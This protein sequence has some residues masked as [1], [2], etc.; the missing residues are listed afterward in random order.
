[1]NIKYCILC[2]IILILLFTIYYYTPSETFQNNMNNELIKMGDFYL[3]MD[4][5]YLAFTS[6][7]NKSEV[8]LS[9]RK[10]DSTKKNKNPVYYNFD[11]KNISLKVD[12]NLDEPQKWKFEKGYGNSLLIKTSNEPSFY[13]A[14]NCDGKV[15]TSQLKRSSDQ[16]WEIFHVSEDNFAIRSLKYRNY[17]TSFNSNGYIFTNN[18]GIV[19]TSKETNTKFWTII[20]SEKGKNEIVSKGKCSTQCGSGIQKLTIRCQKN[21]KDVDPIECINSPKL[22][23]SQ[24]CYDLTGCKPF[25]QTGSWSDCDTKCG[26]GEMKR[27]VRCVYK[28]NNNRIIDA[29]ENGPYCTDPMPST[30]KKCTNS[31]GCK[32]GWF[33]E[34]YGKCS[35]KCGKGKKIREV[36]CKSDLPQ[37]M[38]GKNCDPNKEINRVTNCEDYSGCN[39]FWKTGDW[40][41]CSNFCGEGEMNRSVTCNMRTGPNKSTV[42]SDANCPKPKPISKKK[43]VGTMECRWSP[44]DWSQCDTLCG[45]GKQTRSIDCKNKVG[46]LVNSQYCNS[47]KKPDTTKECTETV[48][49]KENNTSSILSTT[50]PITIIKPSFISTTSTTQP[51][52]T[53]L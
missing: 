49:C 15:F 3:K 10:Y 48:A 22:P 37:N 53:T 19:I 9:D 23:E 8:Y 42:V 27:N 5:K 50:H 51:F 35:T 16:Y 2:L 26:N 38:S 29:S 45:K 20:P 7:Q 31:I 28:L 33:S 46:D 6:T 17:L 1:M 13:L 11:K 18:R 32:Y 25:W 14:S 4:D 40:S 12:I 47:D 30:T 21:C 34:E 41:L 43:C 39:K 36:S 52:I 44:N 24:E